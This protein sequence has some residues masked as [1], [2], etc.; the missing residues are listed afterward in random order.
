MGNLFLVDR[1]DCED[2]SPEKTPIEQLVPRFLEMKS[3]GFA[4]PTLLVRCAGK[5]DEG[6]VNSPSSFR[7][8]N[9]LRDNGSP[10]GIHVHTEVGKQGEKLFEHYVRPE[11]MRV[12]LDKACRL[13]G[14]CFGDE[15][16]IFGMG[17]LACGCED[18]AAMLGDFGLRLDLSDIATGK[19][20]Y[21]EGTRIFDYNTPNWRTDFPVL[22][23]GLWWIPH[24]NDGVHEAFS[25][26]RVRLTLW[27]DPDEDVFGKVFSRYAAIG[28]ANPQRLVIISSLVHPPETLQHWQKWVR[29]H[30]IAIEHGFRS[31]TSV[32]ALTMLEQSRDVKEKSK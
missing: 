10:L 2:E 25:K 17:D 27:Q 12:Q 29:M 30:Q 23:Y 26:C 24:G 3:Q 6:V 9:Q 14:R 18:V 28:R 19:Y 16:R 11:K 7:A 20:R 32:Q 4:M 5:N 22:K 13:F 31:I 1:I 21:H 8:I 15:P